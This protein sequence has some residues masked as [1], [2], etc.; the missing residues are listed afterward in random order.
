MEI[1]KAERKVK[2]SMFLILAHLL[3]SYLVSPIRRQYLSDIYIKRTHE[4]EQLKFL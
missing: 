3:S 2:K 1:D 4:G